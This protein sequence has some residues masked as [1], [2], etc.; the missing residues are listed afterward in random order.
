MLKAQK[1]KQTKTNINAK[2]I[3]TIDKLLTY[4]EVITIIN[5][6]VFNVRNFKYIE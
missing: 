3:L 2:I 5:V 6:F 4:Y 1:T